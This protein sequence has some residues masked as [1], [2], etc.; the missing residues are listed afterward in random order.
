MPL[1]QTRSYSRT[2]HRE[3]GFEIFS[4][5]LIL[6]CVLLCTGEVKQEVKSLMEQLRGEA[7][8]FHKPGEAE[9][10]EAFI[11]HAWLFSI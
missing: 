7:L 10:L 4:L 1:K 2:Q 6:I 5:I 9:H 8:K 11:T 3:L